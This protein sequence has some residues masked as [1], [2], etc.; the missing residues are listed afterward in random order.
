MSQLY[1][2]LRALAERVL[3]SERPDHTLQPTS[4]V[5]EAYLRLAKQD[6]VRWKSRSHFMAMAATMIRRILIDHAR[7]RAALV[8]GGG[9]ERVTLD[10]SDG[11]AT[12][13]DLDLDA[14]DEA[15]RKLAAFDERRSRVVELRFFGGLTNEEI[16]EVL[17][18]SKWTV[19]DD[20]RLA[21][22]WLRRELS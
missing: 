20:W 19:V 10:D 9:R 7:G 12:E 4:L 22:A 16:G 15:L 18:V 5:H 1:D 2:E 14:L 17:G 11:L 3:R 13:G 6:Q 21:R 8:R